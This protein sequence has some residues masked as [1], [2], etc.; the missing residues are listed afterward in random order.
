[1]EQQTQLGKQV[2]R[3]VVEK[4][5]FKKIDSKFLYIPVIFLVLS[6]ILLIYGL[7]QIIG[8][9]S[10]IQ[11]G[12]IPLELL[13]L[14]QILGWGFT[15]LLGYTLSTMILTYILLRDVREHLYNSSIA[16]YHYIGR[17]SLENAI[18]YFESTWLKI[19]L[20]AP[21]TGLLIELLTLG[22]AYPIYIGL[23]EKYVREHA[24]VEEES[25]LKMK[26]TS[27]YSI[28]S[29]TVD[30][31]L[32]FA[33]LGLYLAYMCYRFT[34][35]FNNHIDTI[36]G[37]HPYPPIPP[38]TVREKVE[39]EPTPGYIAG[40]VLLVLG[41]NIL[42]NYIGLFTTLYIGITVGILISILG[43]SMRK[44]KDIAPLIVFSVNL[45]LMYMVAIAGFFSG[46]AGYETY[47]AMVTQQEQQLRNI[48][49][50][51]QV[52][53]VTGLILLI[54]INNFVISISSIIPYIGGLIVVQGA[55][56][57]GLFLGVHSVLENNP[58]TLLLLIYPH[59][60]LELSSY[61]ILLTSTMY[62]R[63]WSKYYRI[64]VIGILLLLLAAFVEVLI[65]I[66]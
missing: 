18:Q 56:N 52:Y 4:I 51:V 27:R 37:N 50:E 31:V 65:I 38:T 7:S 14:A 9:V 39:K 62:F 45:A 41:V 40:L 2:L 3:E 60:I 61:A 29:L 49:R 58:S 53:G 43:L 63:E 34:R 22:L 13:V 44:R 54:F 20:P 19:Q 46:I 57:A 10:K 16:T 6:S 32:V 42:L 25:L 66:Q 26:I 1:M 23:I 55:Y 5:K 36:H 64:I 33:T 35:T 8:L 21:I 59:A 24:I 28:L 11:E 15:A 12:N 30:L 47:K 48:A 17:E